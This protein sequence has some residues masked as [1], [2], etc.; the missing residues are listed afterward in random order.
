MSDTVES[1]RTAID[2]LRKE[3]DDFK[4]Y[5]KPVVDD[6]QPGDPPKFPLAFIPPP[7][8]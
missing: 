6:H 7:R 4:A 1:L 5:A 2:A 8:P 3:F